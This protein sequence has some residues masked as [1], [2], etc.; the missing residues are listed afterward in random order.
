MA[1]IGNCGSGKTTLARALS[2]RMQ[3]QL[4]LEEHEQ[5]PYQRDFM[6]DR[7]RL[8]LQ[9]QM[10]YLLL[11][12]EQERALRSGVG[13]GIVDGGLDQ[14]FYIFTRL[15]YRKGYLNDADYAL[16]E[17]LYRLLRQVLPAP[18]A[19]IRLKAP[20]PDLVERLARRQRPLDIVSPED[21]P[22][23]DSLMDEWMTIDPPRPPAIEIDSTPGAFTGRLLDE[24]VADLRHRL[25]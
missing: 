18:E 2:S 13:I 14:D 12:A 5:R 20:L 22:A 8:G 10:D 4:L 7:S 11:R 23:I 24:L 6:A 3:T 19:T 21:L 15:F 9:N 17:R 1:I 25:T 16:C